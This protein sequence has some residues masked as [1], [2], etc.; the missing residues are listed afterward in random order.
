[1]L[2]MLSIVGQENIQVSRQFHFISPSKSLNSY[3]EA[4]M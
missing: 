4:G 2:E 1:M 3:R